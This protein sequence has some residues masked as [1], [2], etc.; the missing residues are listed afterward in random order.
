MEGRWFVPQVRGY[1]KADLNF[2][3]FGYPFNLFSLDA[4]AYSGVNKI[5]PYLDLSTVKI[6]NGARLFAKILGNTYVDAG[7][8]QDVTIEVKFDQSDQKYIEVTKKRIYEGNIASWQD[9]AKLFEARFPVGP[10]LLEVVSG[11]EGNIRVDAPVDLDQNGIGANVAVRPSVSADTSVFV[12]GGVNYDLVKAGVEADVTLVET[13]ANG[14]LSGMLAYKDEAIKFDV[15]T[16]VDAYFNLIRA[17]FSFYAGTRTHIKWCSSWGVPY[18]CGL[19]WDV[20]EI[21]IYHTPWL[22]SEDM[23]LFKQKL[24]SDTIPMD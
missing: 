4:D 16:E 14:E 21:P 23:V 11:I 2:Y 12:D 19:D 22:F 17:S 9:K 5:H 20:W 6:K 8:I 18:P 7:A 13:G 15:T 10:I 3:L 1:A 24:Y